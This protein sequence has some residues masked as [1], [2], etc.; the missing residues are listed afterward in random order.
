MFININKDYKKYIEESYKTYLATYK[1]QQWWKKI[2]YDPNKKF[3]HNIM[4][5]RYDNYNIIES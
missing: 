4:N 2:L 1:I 3:I 5:N